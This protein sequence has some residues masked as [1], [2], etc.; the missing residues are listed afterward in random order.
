LFQRKSEIKSVKKRL[1]G[2]HKLYG[3]TPVWIRDECIIFLH[4]IVMEVKH[5]SHAYMA[6]VF[7]LFMLIFYVIL[8]LDASRRG[9]TMTGGK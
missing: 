4:G 9:P 6:D 7:Q 5:I 2:D 3:T 1:W 8:V